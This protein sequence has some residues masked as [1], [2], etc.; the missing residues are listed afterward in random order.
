LRFTL[1]RRKERVSLPIIMHLPFIHIQ[2]GGALPGP[3]GLPGLSAIG[4]RRL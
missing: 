2:I 1:D 3:D 4:Q